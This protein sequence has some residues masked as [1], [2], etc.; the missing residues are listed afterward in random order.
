M[1]PGLEVVVIVK[2][3]TQKYTHFHTRWFVCVLFSLTECFT[4]DS[5]G[6]WAGC[7]RLPQGYTATP[8]LVAG[9]W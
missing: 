2:K 9:W 5:L 7:A 6:R 8:M 4:R 3:I 1:L